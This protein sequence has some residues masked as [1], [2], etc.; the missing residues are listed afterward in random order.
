M[1]DGSRPR[2][3]AGGTRT[4]LLESIA[5]ATAPPSGG[6]PP[7]R[8]SARPWGWPGRRRS[9]DFIDS[10][11]RVAG[12]VSSS[13]SIDDV[14]QTVV[15]QA[16]Q[17]VEADKTVLCLA[18]EGRDAT[19]C[20]DD[21]TVVVRG[22]RGQHPESWWHDQIVALAPE[23][24]ETRRPRLVKG[25]GA[26]LLAVPITSRD[27]P[28]GVLVGISSS[29]RTFGQDHVA[30]MS[31]LGALA[32]AAIE[33]ARLAHRAQSSLLA[34]ERGR[35]SREMHDGLSQRLFSVSLNLEVCQRMLRPADTEL[36][37]RLAALQKLVG[38]SLAEVRRYIYDLRP[39]NL[40]RLGL[41]GSINL[42]LTELSSGAGVFGRIYV[43]GAERPVDPAA[44]VCLYR[45]AQEALAN[46][47]R[48]S[49]ARSVTVLLDYREQE[50]V[51]TVEDDGRG[52]DVPAAMAAVE[53]GRSIGLHSMQERVS[54]QAGSLSVVSRR[55]G[56]TVVRATVPCA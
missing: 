20:L 19:T 28:I 31:L 7:A 23:V 29:R 41:P 36:A 21:A 10:L 55:E 16:K 33:N 46:V 14:L 22:S 8:A 45:V 6:R 48:H 38:Q 43:E 39:L 27:K 5:G 35:I 47:A 3:A 49:G 15:D 26:W 25:R 24:C 11:G 2:D 54:A 42:H 12:V 53:E 44:E 50:L 9:D 52:F 37:S 51:M 1:E 56:G 34:E 13:A 18:P 40:D 30:L 4:T 32:G 17:L